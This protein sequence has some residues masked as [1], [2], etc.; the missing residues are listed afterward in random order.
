MVAPAPFALRHRLTDPGAEVGQFAAQLV[1]NLVKDG[2]A[3]DVRVCRGG[4]GLQPFIKVLARLEPFRVVE[5]DQA[6]RAFQDILLGAVVLRHHHGLGVLVGSLEIQ[7]VR[8]AGAAKTVDRLVVVAD[9]GQ[10][11]ARPRRGEE[12][13]QLEL[14]GVGVLEFVDQDPGELL[15]RLFQ[16]QGLLTQQA[17][18]Q[19]QL[20]PM[21][22]ESFAVQDGVIGLV[23]LRQLQLLRSR[24]QLRLADRRSRV[25]PGHLQVV[26]G[27]DGLVLRP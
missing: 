25:G 5:L 10:V 18:H 24:S 12:F 27:R 6:M 26:L 3:G 7:D 19:H 4:H 14:H 15:P 20:I 23:G 2:L 8:Q 13:D 21:V 22:H 11:I 17:Q 16:H 9:Y 1:E